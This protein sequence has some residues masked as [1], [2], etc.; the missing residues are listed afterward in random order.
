MRLNFSIGA[1]GIN[2]FLAVLGNQF[3]ATTGGTQMLKRLQSQDTLVAALVLV[4][5]FSVLHF[6]APNAYAQLPTAA[7]LGTVKDAS[8]GVVPEAKLTARN[9]GTGQSRVTTSAGDGSFRFPSM[10]VGTYEVRA[11]QSGFQVEIRTGL[12]LA[13]G[14]EAVVNF[15]LQLGA[16]EQTVAVTAEAPLVNTTSGSLGGLVNEEKV[17]DLPLNGRNYVDL[18][19]MQLGVSQDN[20]NRGGNTSGPANVGT[21]FSSNG[22]PPRSN[23]Y[24]LD[25]AILQN[26]SNTTSAGSSGSTL[27]V[28][29]VRE[30]RLVTNSFGAEYGLRMGSQMTIVSKSG[31]N[32]FHGSAFEYLRNS[33]LDARNFFDRI[34]P[35][36]PRRLPS[37]TRN[38]FGGAVGGPIKKDKTF[39]YGVFESLKER[40]GLTTNSFTIPAACH[41]ADNVVTSAC[42]SSLGSSTLTVNPVVRPILALYP[43]PNLANNQLTFPFSEPTDEYYGQMRIDQTI[44]TKDTLFMR[45]TGDS[46]TQILP[47]TF[48]QFADSRLSRS[49]YATVSEDHVFSPTILNTARMSFSRTN[50]G[51]FTTSGIIGPTLSFVA[52]QEFGNL[53]IGGVANFGGGGTEPSISVQHIFTWSDDIF[54]T[55]GKHAIKIG[56]QINRFRQ[57]KTQGTNQRGQAV[58]SGVMQFL[59]ATPNSETSVTPGAIQFRDYHLYV[60]GFYIQDDWKVTSRLTLNLGMRYEYSTVPVEA[61]GHASALRDML[62]DSDF[63]VGP[64]WKNNS[65]K[66]FSPR[67]GF[68]WDVQGNGRTAVRGGF[69]ELFDVAN[70]S[71][72][73]DLGNASNPPFASQ[74]SLLNPSVLTVPFVFPAAAVGR[75]PRPADYNMQQPHMLQYNLAIERQLPAQISLT[76]AYAGSRGFNIPLIMEGNPTV[77]SGTVSVA[78]GQRTCLA[79]TPAPVVA[80]SGSP[81]CWTGNDPRV[82]PF[83]DTIEYGTAAG[84]SWY[85]ALQVGL[86]KRLA[87]GLQFQ[88]NYTYSK[89]EDETS[90]QVIGESSVG[91]PDPSNIK[92][93]RAPAGFDLTHNFRFNAIYHFP[94]IAD[95]HGFG[96]V[97]NGWWVSSI[98]T[99]QTGYPLNPRVSSN[100][101]RSKTDLGGFGGSTDRPD[102]V[103]GRKN[104]DI[105]SGTSAG[106]MGVAPGTK[107]GTPDFYID[108]CAFTVQPAGFLGTAGR[109]ILRSPGTAE[110]DF[111]MVKDTAI[112][113]LGEGGRLEFR[114][115]IFNIMNRANF[116]A[117]SSTI[118]AGTGSND[119]HAEAPLAT[120]GKVTRTATSSRQIQL[121]LKLIF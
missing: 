85:N 9:T 115:E 86:V 18:G 99:L 79:L 8:G 113:R 117:P 26:Y 87:K 111:S 52:G 62:H 1:S 31:T 64:V 116:D 7:I 2:H 28:E 112:R 73:R 94:L 120:S 69:G 3:F 93:E 45:Y 47:F 61:H 43:L 44:Y 65:L 76:V 105:T 55:K 39:F 107:L 72:L 82:N 30:F 38:Q 84:S 77:P 11:E 35:T 95:A 118:F 13:V 37:F 108:P 10:P 90:G 81:K 21:W 14:D 60:P 24:M 91:P 96:K 33:A 4:I 32:Q 63:T 40:K 5:L 19:L 54:L 50:L 74:S 16:V 46:D 25:G 15:A 70:L 92:L 89:V 12:T 98:L 102:L 49:Q 110:V 71:S 48:P 80:P 59:S 57:D 68:A 78:N 66:N 101:S 17:A 109:D 34:T 51:G 97:L 27:G 104:S 106:C 121:A 53:N 83:W 36:T 20:I 23:N 103:P 67:F 75:A 29:G 6:G 119:A 88:G 22:A 114:A 42:V 100:R 56:T 58:F 41:T